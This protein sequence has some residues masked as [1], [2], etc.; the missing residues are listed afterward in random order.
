MDLKKVQ[1]QGRDER[2]Q[3]DSYAAEDDFGHGGEQNCMSANK[4]AWVSIMHYF[5]T[6]IVCYVI[7]EESFRF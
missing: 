1:K 5:E 4:I 7:M 3:E 2:T 6:L